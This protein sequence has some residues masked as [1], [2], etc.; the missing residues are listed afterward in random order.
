MQLQHI[1]IHPHLRSYIYVDSID[2]TLLK[3]QEYGGIIT[4]GKT[5]LPGIG[6]IAYAPRPMLLDFGKSNSDGLN[7]LFTP[8]SGGV[9]SGN[10]LSIF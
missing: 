2:A 5:Q 8:P 10:Y 4:M 1:P 9:K 3:M 6:H 7:F